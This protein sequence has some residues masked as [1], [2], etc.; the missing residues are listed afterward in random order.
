MSYGI[1]VISDKHVRFGFFSAQD[2]LNSV[3]QSFPAPWSI[4]ELKGKYYGT[5]IEDA[6][7]TKILS[8]WKSAGAP[9]AR[10]FE[11]FTKEEWE[12]YCCDSHWESQQTYAICEAIVAKRN[13][14]TATRWTD[15]DDERELSELVIRYGHWEESVWD[16]IQCGGRERR[17]ISA[18]KEIEP[19]TID[20]VG[21]HFRKKPG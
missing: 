19:T 17:I 1:T 18:P 16:K 11:G 3:V 5:I 21:A 4:A 2:W 14:I 20:A 9:S 7:G 6:E 10:Q 15:A 8:V 12:D 13:Y